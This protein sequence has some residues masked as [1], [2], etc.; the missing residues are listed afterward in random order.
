MGQIVRLN[1]DG[2]PV[3]TEAHKHPTL[4]ELQEI[5]GGYIEIVYVMYGGK[6]IQMIVNEDGHAMS[7][8]LNREATHIYHAT[9]ALR[10]YR[11][12]HPIV[13]DAVLLVGQDIQL[14]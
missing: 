13:G 8:P 5:V 2:A 10:G 14:E 12:E 4:E 11:T 6:R 1:T 9:A 3:I 7:L